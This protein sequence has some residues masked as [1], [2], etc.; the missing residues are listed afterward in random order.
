MFGLDEAIPNSSVWPCARC[1]GTLDAI[2]VRQVLTAISAY[3]ATAH[4]IWYD[5]SLGADA[6]PQPSQKWSPLQIL[7]REFINTP[8]LERYQECRCRRDYDRISFY[9]RS[10]CERAGSPY[11]LSILDRR[12]SSFGRLRTFFVHEISPSN[13]RETYLDMTL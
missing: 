11:I 7:D 1:S 10:C 3:A 6:E 2:T 9:T 4:R 13:L 12:S 5:E 8:T